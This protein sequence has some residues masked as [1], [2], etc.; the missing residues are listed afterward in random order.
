[1]KMTT[2]SEARKAAE[3]AAEK[4][5]KSDF[6][7]G[8]VEGKCLKR[9]IQPGPGQIKAIEIVMNSF[10]FK[11]LVTKTRFTYFWRAIS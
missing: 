8:V 7:C 6:I 3:A 1:M 5:T 11:F 2:R 10:I 9:G 4:E